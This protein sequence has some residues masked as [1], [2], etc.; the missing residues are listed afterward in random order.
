M[1]AQTGNVNISGILTDGIE[2]PT[3]NLEFLTTAISKKLT[4][5]LSG[6]CDD[7]QSEMA[8]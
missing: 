2:V 6:F 1:A 5:G 4:S 3:A 7:R 8:R